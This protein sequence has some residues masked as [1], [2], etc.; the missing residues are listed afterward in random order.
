MVYQ[1]VS[2]R[3]SLHH[4]LERSSQRYT[5]LRSN[6][7]CDDQAFVVEVRLVIKWSA[8]AI[9]CRRV[10]PARRLAHTIMYFMP[11]PSLPSMFST[12][13][14]TSSRSMKVVPLAWPP[15]TGILRMLTPS[16]F[17]RGTSK[18]LSPP[19]PSPPVLT[20]M[21]AYS[22]HIPLV[23]HFLVPLTMKCFPSGVL[24]AVVRTLATCV[25]CQSVFHSHFESS[26]GHSY[27]RPSIRLGDGNADPSPTGQKV[28]EESLLQFKAAEVNDGRNSERKTSCDSRCRAH[29]SA[30]NHLGGVDGHMQIVEILDGNGANMVDS[31]TLQPLD[32]QRSRQVGNQHVVFGKSV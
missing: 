25:E 1:R 23:I 20:H 27:I 26:F 24:S 8:V 3:L 18:T 30:A 31:N 19:G 21:D 10:C 11:S 16:W 32:R 2:E 15:L 28:G 6:E 12:G 5:S 29:Q 14:F 9:T 13:T 7:S 17:F 22:L 4:P